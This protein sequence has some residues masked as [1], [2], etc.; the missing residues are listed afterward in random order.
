[1]ELEKKIKEQKYSYY[2]IVSASG[3]TGWVLA[4]KMTI[5]ERD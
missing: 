5:Q 3:L 1:M 2:I 4:K